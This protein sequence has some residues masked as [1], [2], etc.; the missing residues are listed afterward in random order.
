MSLAVW[1]LAGAVASYFGVLGL[2]LSERVA[3]AL[4]LLLSFVPAGM[5]VA[6]VVLLEIRRRD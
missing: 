5:L 2:S 6:S 3:P 4:V 1:L